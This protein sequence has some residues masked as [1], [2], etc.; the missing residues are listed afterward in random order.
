[1]LPYKYRLRY[2]QIFIAYSPE[3]Y[4]KAVTTI[5]EIP[6]SGSCEY[7][8]IDGHNMSIDSETVRNWTVQI[9]D[10]AGNCSA[11]VFPEIENPF[12][13]FITANWTHVS[14]HVRGEIARECDSYTCA[15]RVIFREMDTNAIVNES[16]CVARNIRIEFKLLLRCMF[17][18]NILRNHA[19]T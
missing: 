4:W 17:T 16:S 7:I 1:M 11:C 3:P 8:L 5:V 19:N 15:V 6:D 12:K 18:S 10:P 9:S 14:V 13:F 2:D